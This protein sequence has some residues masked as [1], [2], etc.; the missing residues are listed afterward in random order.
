MHNG[1]LDFGIT[2][3]QLKK[4]RRK[5]WVSLAGIKSPESV[6]D[7]TYRTAILV[8]CLSDLKGLNTEK[9]VR[10]ALLHDVHEALIGV[11][12]HSDKERIG[13]SELRSI[14][15]EAVKRVFS[16]LPDNLQEKYILL[17]AEFQGQETEEARLIKQ[18]DQIEMIFQAL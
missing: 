9:L 4:I 14:E 7:H 13:K 6:A 17:S 11:Y 15:T 12:D 8:M 3:G 18:I 1:V 5:G 10:M 16:D 2:A